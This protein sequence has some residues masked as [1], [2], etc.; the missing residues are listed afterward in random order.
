MTEPPGPPQS[1]VPDNPTP[2]AGT[3]PPQPFPGG[4]APY[5]PSAYPPSPYPPSPYPPSA[6]PPHEYLPPGTYSPPGIYP[7]PPYPGYAAPL[8]AAPRNG[9]ATGAIIASVLS[10]PAA[11]TVFGGFILAIAGIILGVMG[12]NRARRGEATNPGVAIASIVLGVL[13]IIL[14]AALIALGVWGFLKVGGGDYVDCIRQAGSDT[15]AKIQCEE[16][17]KD[18][19]N[20]RL[21]VTPTPPR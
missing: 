14:S 7:P 15:A 8:P 6:Y 21:S 19:L 20:E 2:S 18:S 3:P 10:L 5:P 17:F 12:Y 9:L 13:G 4:Y 11:F 1:P 16:Q